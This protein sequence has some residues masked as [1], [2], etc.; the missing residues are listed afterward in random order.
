[1]DF[2]KQALAISTLILIICASA[3]F[4]PIFIY[5]FSSKNFPKRLFGLLGFCNFLTVFYI[6]PF[7]LFKELFP[8]NLFESVNSVEDILNATSIILFT[9]LKWKN[10]IRLQNISCMKIF[11]FGKCISNT[12]Y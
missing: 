10:F 7:Y 5:N 9:L 4:T 3:C 12:Y 2:F 6:M 11:F 8:Q 1:M